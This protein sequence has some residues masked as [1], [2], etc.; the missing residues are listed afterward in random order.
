M[1]VDDVMRFDTDAYAI[2]Q[3]RV[4]SSPLELTEHDFDQL[5]IISKKSEA[6]ARE[7]LK[8]A[9]IALVEANAAKAAAL[10]TKSAEPEP[11]PEPDGM[12]QWLQKHGKRPATYQALADVT[13][14]LIERWKEMNERNKERNAR[15]DTLEQRLTEQDARILELEAQRAASAKVEV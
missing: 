14:A 9:Q 8:Q 6:D 5:G 2:A 4:T 13:D 10:Q 15:L 11:E 7:A 1:N 3:Q 12:T